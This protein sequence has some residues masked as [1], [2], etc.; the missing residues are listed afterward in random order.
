[1]VI[2]NVRWEKPPLGWCKLNTDGAAFGNPGRAGGGVV[3]RDSEGRW[4]RGFARPI[5][6]TTSITAEFWALRDGLL[7]AVRMGVQK[8]VIELDANVVVE[9]MQSYS[10]SNAFYSSLMAD[11]RSFLGKFQHYRV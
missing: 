10:P 3:I 4:V 5:G 11:C 8:L 2:C 9:L 7:L 6:F 1:M